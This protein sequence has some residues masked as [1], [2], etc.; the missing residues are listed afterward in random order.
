MTKGPDLNDTLRNEGEDAVRARS[1]RAEKYE[2]NGGGAAP[3]SS[4]ITGGK[5]SGSKKSTGKATADAPEFSDEA[6]ALSFAAAHAD[7]LRY[8]AAS[9]SWLMWD[10]QI[11]RYDDTLNVYDLVRQLCRTAATVCRK[12]DK[13]KGLASAKTVAAVERLARSD[14]RLAASVEQ[15]D[16]DPWLVTCTTVTVDLRTGHQPS[17]SLG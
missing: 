16:A 11:W 3:A 8:V 2:P 10:G 17:A 5:K 4:T 15:W 9:N 12:P 7:D 14:R 1:D 6:L 13:A